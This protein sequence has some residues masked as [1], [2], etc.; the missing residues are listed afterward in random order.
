MSQRPWRYWSARR[1]AEPSLGRSILLALFAVFLTYHA[2]G[3]AIH[4]APD[5]IPG[6]I[7]MD[8][9]FAALAIWVDRIAI[10]RA[11]ETFAI[12]KRLAPN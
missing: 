7:I 9:A 10:Q 11:R 4:P 2:V 8:A 5:N 1:H 3:L 12:R 6:D